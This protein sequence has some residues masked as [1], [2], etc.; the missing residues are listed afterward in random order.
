MLV[1]TFLYEQFDGESL[2]YVLV[3]GIPWFAYRDV[4]NYLQNEYASLVYILKK[5]NIGKNDGF[6]TVHD[7]HSRNAGM[8]CVEP[9]LLFQIINKMRKFNRKRVQLLIDYYQNTY[10]VVLALDERTGNCRE[11]NKPLSDEDLRLG[12]LYCSEE[13]KRTWEL[14]R[15]REYQHSLWLLKVADRPAYN[16]CPTCG[17]E[18][19]Y[20]NVKQ[21]YCS[22]ECKHLAAANRATN[23]HKPVEPFYHPQLLYAA[24]E[25]DECN[26]TADESEELDAY[27]RRLHAWEWGLVCDDLK[28]WK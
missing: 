23:R 26:L 1:D 28:T 5:L 25:L 17:K 9:K 10:G 22:P 13:C 24:D 6:V 3:K 4:K 20:K 19:E 14:R 8:D 15:Q 11:C 2:R 12:K 18:F 27:I 7:A 16:V 21:I